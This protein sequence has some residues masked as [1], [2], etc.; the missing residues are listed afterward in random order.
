MLWLARALAVLVRGRCAS[1]TGCS[2]SVSDFRRLTKRET[3][4]GIAHPATY[5]RV[6][7]RPRDPA[8]FTVNAPVTYRAFP[9]GM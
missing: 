7:N 8:D 4:I 2:R 1:G 6:C 9:I 5:A 3:R